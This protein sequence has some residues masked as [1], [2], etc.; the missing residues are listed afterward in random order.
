MAIGLQVCYFLQVVNPDVTVKEGPGNSEEVF[1]KCTVPV[2]CRYH[3]NCRLSLDLF[4]IPTDELLDRCQNKRAEAVALQSTECGIEIFG[5]SARVDDQNWRD[6]WNK[7]K[8]TS[9]R[10]LEV[11]GTVDGKYDERSM[12]IILKSGEFDGHQVWSNYRL[13]PIKVCSILFLMKYFAEIDKQTKAT[14]LHTIICIE[15]KIVLKRT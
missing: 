2:F 4:T 7:I 9:S 5:I 6:E 8:E 15:E 13:S 14:V 11:T 10:P 12:L 3:G 1:V